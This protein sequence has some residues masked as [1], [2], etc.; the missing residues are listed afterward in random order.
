MT[1][2]FRNIA[3]NGNRGAADLLA[4]TIKLVPGKIG[5]TAVNVSRQFHGVLPNPQVPER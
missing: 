4:Q 3:G 2:A 5:R 1:F